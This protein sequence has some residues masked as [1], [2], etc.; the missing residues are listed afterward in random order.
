VIAGLLIVL[1][2]IGAFALRAR[3]AHR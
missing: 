3:R 1:V 2:A